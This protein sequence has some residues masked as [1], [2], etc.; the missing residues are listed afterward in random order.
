MQFARSSKMSKT[1]LNPVSPENLDWKMRLQ[2]PMTP[3]FSI[4]TLEKD[5]HQTETTK[6]LAG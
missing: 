2:P 5:P 1:K 6:N 4:K 3:L